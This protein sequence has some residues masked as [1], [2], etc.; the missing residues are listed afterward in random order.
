[1]RAWGWTWDRLRA[2]TAL[3]LA[4]GLLVAA[5]AAASATTCQAWAAPRTVGTATNSFSGVALTSG[6][7][8]WAVGVWAN[9]QDVESLVEHW[10]GTG[11]SVQPS[12]DPSSHNNDLVAV[13]ATS[14]SNAWA[15]GSYNP[16]NVLGANLPLILHWNGTAWTQTTSSITDSYNYLTAVSATSATSAWAVG[17]RY[18][19][20]A[21]AYQTLILH[22]NGT[23]WTPQPSPNPTGSNGSYLWGVTATSA[24]NAWAV[25]SS[26]NASGRR[27]SQILH[28]DGTTWT[29]VAN[30]NPGQNWTVLDGVTATSSSNA[31]A[32]GLYYN[33]ST[34]QSLV[35]RW[36]GTAWT[37]VPSP[38]PCGT[39]NALSSVAASSATNA[40]AVGECSPEAPPYQ[41]LVE[42]WNG[43]TWTLV[44]NPDPGGAPGN[45]LSAVAA[46]YS[47]AGAVG[48]YYDSARGVDQP[49]ALHL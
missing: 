29:Q 31:W 24:S 34:S 4:V 13:A 9:G 25:G 23:A 40:W 12:P 28:W 26:V 48:Y 43:S 17:Y 36:D 21:Q 30:P 15:V 38:S 42:H 18:S 35:E 16:D 45:A 8:A 14:A 47:N 22:W 5:P 11:W 20:T 27:T 46:R 41:P 44:P 1:M 32:V 49:L 33:G 3:A 6:C 19:H 39:T 37:Q 7:A 2:V 10:N